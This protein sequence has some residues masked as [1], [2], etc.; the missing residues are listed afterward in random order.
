[1]KAVEFDFEKAVVSVKRVC[2]NPCAQDE[3]LVTVSPKNSKETIEVETLGGIFEPDEYI[4]ERVYNS[5]FTQ[6]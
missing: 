6:K 3:Y 1:M 5:V 4:A 2:A